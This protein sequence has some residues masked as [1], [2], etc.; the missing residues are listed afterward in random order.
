MPGGASFQAD[1]ISHGAVLCAVEKGTHALIARLLYGTGVRLM[2][3]L[4]LRVKDIDF[5]RGQIV[6]R[7]GKGAKEPGDGAAG[8]VARRAQSALAPG[9]G[10]AR[11]GS[12]GGPNGG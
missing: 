4:R 6:V 11:Q 9:A 8:D 1:G 2:E 12:G 7:A 5:T 10:V 3:G